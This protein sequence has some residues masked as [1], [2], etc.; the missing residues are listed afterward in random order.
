MDLIIMMPFYVMMGIMAVIILISLLST[1]LGE[2]VAGIL[3]S[4]LN[5]GLNVLFLLFPIG[6]MIWMF[7]YV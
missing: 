4:G 3:L 5:V 1:D 2:K 7:I 6:F